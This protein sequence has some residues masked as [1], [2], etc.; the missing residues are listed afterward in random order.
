MLCTVV[1]PAQTRN[2]AGEPGTAES[3]TR[4]AAA[5]PRVSY[6]KH[7]KNHNVMRLE[8]RP[9]GELRFWAHQLDPE[10]AA[11]R[12]VLA[13]RGL[14]IDVRQ[15]T[16][17]YVLRFCGFGYD[18]GLKY[19]DVRPGDGAFE[20]VV[21]VG[22]DFFRGVEH[23]RYG[24]MRWKV[25]VRR[26]DERRLHIA[27]RLIGWRGVLMFGQARAETELVRMAQPPDA[28]TPSPVYPIGLRG[29]TD[30]GALA[31]GRSDAPGSLGAVPPVAG[32]SGGDRSATRGR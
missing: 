23:P 12:E 1:L 29:V 3:G 25:T 18:N 21:A 24:E 8:E 20:A 32:V 6:W 15:M 7:P 27:G 10:D 26:V 11:T 19:V 5:A 4:I 14:E 9:D 31:G 13:R 30:A 2:P 17:E 16:P 28:C 22:F